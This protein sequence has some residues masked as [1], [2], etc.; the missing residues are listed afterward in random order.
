MLIYDATTGLTLTNGV[1]LTLPI[2]D[3]EPSAISLAVTKFSTLREMLKQDFR[4]RMTHMRLASER[5]HQMLGDGLN[6]KEEA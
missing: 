2:A 1:G 3:C 5:I 6:A 4:S